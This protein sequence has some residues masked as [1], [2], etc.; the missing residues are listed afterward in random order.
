MT[1]GDE[2]RGTDYSS[3]SKMKGSPIQPPSLFPP[4]FSSY[5]LLLFRIGTP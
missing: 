5:L 4:T 1:G 2:T 3:V